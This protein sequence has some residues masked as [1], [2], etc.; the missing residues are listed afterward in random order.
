MTAG[1]KNNSTANK[2]GR[3]SNMGTGKRLLHYALDYK[4]LLIAGIVLLGFAVTA[5][6]MGPMIAKKNN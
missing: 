6:L 4:K 5:D 2:S 1:I 3:L